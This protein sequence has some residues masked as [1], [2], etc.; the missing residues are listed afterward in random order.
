MAEPMYRRIAEDL[1]RRIESGELPPGARLPSEEDLREEYGPDG[2]SVSR[3]TVRDALRLL[4]SRGLI[5]TR[6]GQGT[7]VLRKMTTL[8]TK[9]NTDQASGMSDSLVYK[10]EVERQGRTPDDTLRV[11]LQGASDLVAPQLGLSEGTQ[12]I[13]R[14]Q[15]RRIDGAPWSLQTTYY[16]FDL[17]LKIRRQ[18]SSLWPPASRRGLSRGSRRRS[19]SA[20][21]GG[22][23]PSS[24]GRPTGAK[25]TS[26]TCR[27]EFR[28]PCS[29]S[30]ALAMR[31]TQPDPVHDHDLPRGPLPVRDGGRRRSSCVTSPSPANRA[32]PPGS[33]TSNLGT[34][35]QNSAQALLACQLTHSLTRHLGLV[36]CA[37]FSWVLLLLGTWAGKVVSRTKSV[38]RLVIRTQ[39]ASAVV[40]ARTSGVSCSWRTV[41]LRITACQCRRRRLP[42]YRQQRRRLTVP[43]LGS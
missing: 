7:F 24:R 26:S 39:V 14:H 25:E 9:L 23:T 10:E 33:V 12:V 8:I 17:V 21:L 30:G 13:L 31:R 35:L 40:A 29:S 38:Q 18:R 4:V 15:E 34:W 6:P 28:S 43:Y 11:E 3:N 36:V 32:P 19:G 42:S 41:L 16:P 27:T 5:E 22:A 2:S 37:Q 20:R 1:R